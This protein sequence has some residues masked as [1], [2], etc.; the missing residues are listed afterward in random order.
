MKNLSKFLV[1]IYAYIYRNYIFAV[2][3]VFTFFDI[4]FWPVVGIISIGV[5]SNFL[6]LDKQNISF[7][8]TGAITS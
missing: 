7:L 2:R 3:N 6:K 1:I 4:L 8:L 5:M